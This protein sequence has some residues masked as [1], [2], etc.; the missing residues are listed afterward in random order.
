MYKDKLFFKLAYV[1]YNIDV[2][3]LL[4]L[5]TL[6]YINKYFVYMIKN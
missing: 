6:Y 3:R 1:I 5:I 2:N 4:L